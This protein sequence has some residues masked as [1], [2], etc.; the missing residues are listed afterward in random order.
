MPSSFCSALSTT[1][2]PRIVLE[3]LVHDAKMPLPPLCFLCIPVVCPYRLFEDIHRRVRRPENCHGITYPNQTNIDFHSIE[4]DGFF[5]LGCY[6]MQNMKWII[7]IEFQCVVTSLMIVT[8]VLSVDFA[9][10]ET[11]LRQTLKRTQCYFFRHM[12][13]QDIHW[14]CLTIWLIVRLIVWLLVFEV[15]ELCSH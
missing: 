7:D 3:F 1:Q 4:I 11:Q 2:H 12:T 14:E 15:D 6:E 5:L 9:L 10:C 8:S 13:W